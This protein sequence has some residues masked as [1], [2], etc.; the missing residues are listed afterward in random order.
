MLVVT[1]RQVEIIREL[2]KRWCV[3]KSVFSLKSRLPIN[4]RVPPPKQNFKE[5]KKEN[6]L[7]PKKR[8][9]GH[10]I[11]RGNGGNLAELFAQNVLHH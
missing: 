9:E 6:T 10:L 7:P 4:P 2:S 1:F 8:V 3:Q 5:I 11:C